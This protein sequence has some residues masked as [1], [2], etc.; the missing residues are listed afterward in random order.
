MGAMSMSF[1]EA[2]DNATVIFDNDPRANTDPG[3]RTSQ[4]PPALPVFGITTGTDD[5][6]Q[7]D[8][9]LSSDDVIDLLHMMKNLGWVAGEQAVHVLVFDPN[10]PEHAVIAKNLRIKTLTPPLHI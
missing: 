5:Q 4:H 7:L 2:I 10:E 9:S 3:H 8:W 1:N 6:G